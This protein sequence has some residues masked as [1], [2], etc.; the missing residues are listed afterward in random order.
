M[1][2]KILIANRGEIAVRI[3]RACREMGIDTVAVYSEADAESLHVSL[4]DEAYCIGASAAS[5]SYLNIN[6]VLMAAKCS[7]ADAI[8]PGY[9][10][11][12]ENADFAQ[13]CADCDIVFIG[14][15]P[16]VIAKM[17]DKEEARRTMQ[18][19]GVPVVLGT[20]VL[21]NADAGAEAADAIGYPVML[22]ARSGGGGRG[23]RILR[24]PAEF[25]NTFFSAEAEAEN[26]FGDPA[27]YLEK[28][29]YPVKHIEVQLLCDQYGN[30]IALGD[31]DCSV[32]RKNQK[33]IEEAP[34]PALPDSVREKMYEA[35]VEAAK[36][37]GYVTVGTVEFL[38]PGGQDFYFMEMNTRLQVEHPVTEMVSGVDIVKWQIRTAAGMKIG[39]SDHDIGKKGCAI[40]CRICAEH[41]KTFLPNAGR[42]SFMHV[43]GGLGVRF[44]THLYQDYTIPPCY[45]SMI[46]KLIVY[47]CSREA[48]L[49]KMRSALSELVI[50]GIEH[51]IDLHLEILS[52]ECFIDGTH[53]T[54]FLAERGYIG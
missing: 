25:R 34:S 41:P 8:H 31:R 51:N 23:I 33:L 30:A 11:L 44:D 48:A 36:A 37:V 19:A 16:E 42:I 47:A 12:A 45:D 39:F 18:K 40:E 15:S 26:A 38:W 13:M 43:P 1:F 54:A 35:A 9:G 21:E 52:D 20:E 29:L 46:G 28:Y 53:T 24:D 6:A 2:S 49:R 4:A 22:K 50:T 32:Q 27:L 14:P 17:G 7:G 5:E 10:L 3:I